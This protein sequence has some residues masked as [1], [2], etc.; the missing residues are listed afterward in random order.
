VLLQ[1]QQQQ[2]HVL[3]E[4][5]LTA[6]GQTAHGLCNHLQSAV[7]VI[8]LQKRGEERASASTSA[9]IEPTAAAAAPAAGPLADEA[10]EPDE[11]VVRACIQ[12]KY[13]ST[14]PAV[15]APAVLLLLELFQLLAAYYDQRPNE[16]G[17]NGLLLQVL[18]HCNEL[19]RQ[20]L[21]MLAACGSVGYCIRRSVVLRQSGQQLLQLLQWQVQ[22]QVRRQRAGSSSSSS[23]SSACSGSAASQDDADSS[24]HSVSEVLMTLMWAAGAW[25]PLATKKDGTPRESADLQPSPLHLL[26]CRD[27]IHL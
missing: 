4:P 22:L 24:G 20:Q 17:E 26:S 16:R 23:S 12:T 18:D 3:L 19:L 5:S 11:P 15:A 27:K 8:N 7:I 9:G 21:S 2:Q 25:D 13:E 14:S 1:Q 10:D 6:V